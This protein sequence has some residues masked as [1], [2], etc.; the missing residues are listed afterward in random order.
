MVSSLGDAVESGTLTKLLEP[1]SHT[2]EASCTSL[3][4]LCQQ[5]PLVIFIQ[6]SN[7]VILKPTSGSVI[8]GEALWP[9][10]AGIVNPAA[11]TFTT[12]VLASLENP[13]EGDTEGIRPGKDVT[14]AG[15]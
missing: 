7:F 8:S 2:A 3:L 14:Q 1:V 6:T 4:I 10:K 15:L 11:R 9:Q 13:A 12:D 5:S